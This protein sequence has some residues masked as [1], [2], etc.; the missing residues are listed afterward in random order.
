M[1]LVMVFLA[2]AGGCRRNAPQHEVVT[3]RGGVVRIPMEQVADGQA[4][5]FT[6]PHDGR[7]VNFFIRKDGQSIVRAHFDACHSCYKY[8]RGYVQEGRQVVCIACR[9]GYDLETSVWDYVG[10]CVPINLKC[11][12]QDGAVILPVPALQKGSRFF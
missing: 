2:V 3:S 4:H 5:F 9:I 8:R 12:I 6:Y 11:R 7:N 1:L 10:P